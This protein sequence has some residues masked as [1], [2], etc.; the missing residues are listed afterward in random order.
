MGHEVPP[1]VPQ[2]AKARQEKKHSRG[3]G[4]GFAAQ[5]E[6]E[7]RDILASLDAACRRR[8]P[9]R[10]QKAMERAHQLL[11]TPGLPPQLAA[12]AVQ[13]C[14]RAAQLLWCIAAERA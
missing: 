10:I 6:A 14:Q 2:P 8:S 5:A 12:E 4:G 1:A 3:S 7:S 13:A 11:M 9:T